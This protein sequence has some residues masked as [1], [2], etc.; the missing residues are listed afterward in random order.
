MAEKYD[1]DSE[2]VQKI[3]R[4]LQDLEKDLL[5]N[6]DLTDPDDAGGRLAL[7]KIFQGMSEE[8][9]Y[10]LIKK[11]NLD[12]SWMSLSLNGNKYSTVIR[13]LETIEHLS[14]ARDRDALTGL[15][16]RGFFQRV[17]K[18]EMEK[19]YTYKVP[20]TLAVLDIDDFKLINDTFGHVCGDE[21]IKK[22]AGILDS[23]IRSGDYA[24]RI[25]GE[26]FA[27]I[28]PGTGK[29]KSDPLLNRILKT[30]DQ[31][32]VSCNVGN[33]DVSYTVSIGSATYRGRA[34]LSPEELFSQADKQLYNVKKSGKN[35]ISSVSAQETIDDSSMVRR[36]EKDFLLKG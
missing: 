9:W 31:N 5:E 22:L 26:E 32:P 6:S 19:S 17:L 24:S 27:L 21:V 4:E 35:S 28:L 23:Q 33:E 16:N 13:L 18:R 15:S 10:S 29:I 30:A 2:Q 20:L 34:K 36:D 14:I 8:K 12:P 1:Q 7:V 11:A 3:I 25:G